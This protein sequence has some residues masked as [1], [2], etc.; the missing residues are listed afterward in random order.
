[1]ETQLTLSKET[2]DLNNEDQEEIRKTNSGHGSHWRPR[3]ELPS[4]EDV[5]A[6]IIAC[7]MEWVR[8]ETETNKPVSSEEKEGVCAPS[9]Q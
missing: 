8:Q 9:S 6:K 2:K 3:I 5:D 1:M 7:E 4:P